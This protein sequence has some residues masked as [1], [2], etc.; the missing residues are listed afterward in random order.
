MYKMK[1]NKITLT[2]NKILYKKIK[3]LTILLLLTTI[4]FKIMK[5]L[6]KILQLIKNCIN[7]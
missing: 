7:Q 4:R 1:N 3:H 6:K 2:H 5:K